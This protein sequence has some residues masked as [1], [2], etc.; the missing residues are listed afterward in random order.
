MKS[1]VQNKFIFLLESNNQEIPVFDEHGNRL[2][3]TLLR[4]S[5]GVVCQQPEWRAEHATCHGRGYRG[6]R[7]RG[8]RGYRPRRGFHPRSASFPLF[9]HHFSTEESNSSSS[10]PP[11]PLSRPPYRGGY[12]NRG[13][14][15][16][17]VSSLSSQNDL[18][19]YNRIVYF[20]PQ[21]SCTPFS[22][23][24][25]PYRGYRGT[26]G[27]RGRFPRGTRFSNAGSVNHDQS[28]ENNIDSLQRLNI[29]SYGDSQLR[30]VET[31][32][33]IHFE[34]DVKRMSV[35]NMHQILNLY[36]IPYEKISG[37]KDKLVERVITVWQLLN[38]NIEVAEKPLDYKEEKAKTC[39]ICLDFPKDTIMLPCGHL[40]TCYNCCLQ[41]Q[42]CKFTLIIYNNQFLISNYF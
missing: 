34:D 39:C 27:Y 38:T 14:R 12:S 11:R 15:G 1:F 42:T 41:C 29:G 10:P 9:P 4:N 26:R 35:E 17:G 18:P 8:I 32:D 3:I 6:Y 37:D 19:P 2:N 23:D 5:S 24:S 13:I 36:E 33:D 7:P 16:S 21:P 40:A 30:S 25:V 22:T 20:N 31:I 28:G